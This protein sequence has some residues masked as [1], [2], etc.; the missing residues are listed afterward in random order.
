[1]G[2]REAYNQKQLDNG[3]FTIEEVSELVRRFQID[4]NLVSDGMYG[5]NTKRALGVKSGPPDYKNPRP[6]EYSVI[7]PVP[8]LPDGREPKVTSGHHTVN[9]SR[10][11]G[12]YKNRD[13]SLYKGHQGI[14]ILFR[15]DSQVDP[16][17]RELMG[18]QYDGNWWVPRNTVAL[19]VAEGTVIRSDDQ[20]NGGRVRLELKDGTQVTYRHLLE[21]EVLVG[22]HVQQGDVVGLV[23]GDPRHNGLWHLHF[24]VRFDEY[25]KY[26][27]SVNPEPW[28]INAEY[29]AWPA[30]L[31]YPDSCD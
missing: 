9:P 13:G 31:D 6:P 30:E 18:A 25:Y 2:K 26:S 27:Q 7:F 16:V 3:K 24:E 5:P 22:N 17:K 12:A 14:D 1:M 4:S 10:A 19:A 28:L 15:Y 29:L 20:R 8:L 21:R 23:G 11:P